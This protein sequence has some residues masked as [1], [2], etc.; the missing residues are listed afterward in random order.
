[1][2]TLVF[3]VFLVLA[4]IAFVSAANKAKAEKE[5][6]VKLRDSDQQNEPYSYEIGKHGNQTLAIRY[7]I[8]NTD[9]E[10]IPYYYHA[11]GGVKKR[12][13]DRDRKKIV[14]SKF[15][16]LRKLKKLNGENQFLV[17][18]SGFKNRKAIAIHVP[19]ENFIRTFY[20]INDKLDNVDHGWWKRNPELETALKDNHTF[21]LKEMAK[22]H[23]DKIV[24]VRYR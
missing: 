13:F 5:R 24:P 18:L 4:V 1:M 20:P 11:K 3:V 10:V 7:G 21:T 12:N 17:E 2:G 16:K 15:I 14:D 8:A 19:G 6:L 22:F 23:V 9:V